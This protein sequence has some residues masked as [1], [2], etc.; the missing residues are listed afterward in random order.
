MPKRLSASQVAQYRRDGYAFPVDIYSA[1]EVARYRAALEAIEAV[2]GQPLHGYQKQKTYLL[3]RWAYDAVTHPNMLDAIEDLIGPNIM[4]FNFSTW[5]K[6]PESAGMVSW[7]Q[8]STYFGLEPGEQVIT[9]PYTNYLDMDRL[10]LQG[11]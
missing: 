5:I 6:D 8:D 2:Q 10:E 3:F 7:H 9:S 4:V 11:E 1:Q